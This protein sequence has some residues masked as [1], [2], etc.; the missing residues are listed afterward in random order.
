MGGNFNCPGIGWSTGNLIDS[1]SPASF[2][3]SLIEF[4]QDFLLEQIVFEPTRGDNILDLCFTTHP[5]IIHQCQ[6]VPGFSDHHM[7]AVIVKILCKLPINKK[8]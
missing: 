2:H 8:T 5:G 1:Y 7:H 3:K 6:T 4:V